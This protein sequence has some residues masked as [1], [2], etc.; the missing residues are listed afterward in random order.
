[1]P[2]DAPN[3]I[4]QLLQDVAAGRDGAQRALLDQV[5][6]QLRAIAGNAMSLERPGHTL[7]ATAL[8][9]EAYVRMLG[10]AAEG[11][12]VEPSVA[13]QSGVTWRDRRHFYRAAAEAMRRIL[14]EHA[15]RR[16]AEKRGGKH[17]RTLLNVC[18]LAAE[19]NSEE[20]LAIDQAILRL[21]DIDPTAAE[22]VR[23]R[24]FAGLSVEQTAAA[25]GISDRSVR[26]EWTYAR[27]KLFRLLNEPSDS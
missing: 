5:Y 20:I 1:V 26:R 25:M 15:R 17:K 23:L 27:A 6:S 21:D 7:Q 16:G 4:T 9:H 13:Q 14:I 12:D 8:V 22:I 3:A 11:D 18:E 10:K 2:A 24:F 19:D